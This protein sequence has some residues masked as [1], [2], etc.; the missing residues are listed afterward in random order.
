MKCGDPMVWFVDFDQI[1][2]RFSRLQVFDKIKRKKN[3][4]PNNNNNKKKDNGE[5]A[6]DAKFCKIAS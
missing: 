5:K 1:G 6:F 4:V 3:P 2:K